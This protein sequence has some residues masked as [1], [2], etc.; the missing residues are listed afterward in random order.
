MRRRSR[1]ALILAA[2][3]LL[4]ALAGSG[5][6]DPGAARVLGVFVWRAPANAGFGGLSGIELGADGRTMT[7]L[8]DR[9]R[10]GRG[11][12]T[13]DAAGRITAA[14][15]GPLLRLHDEKG[16]L[17]PR[18]KAD[19]EGLAIAADGRI[20]ISFEGVHLLRVYRTPDGPGRPLPRA[21][22]FAGLPGNKSLETL[23]IDAQ[24]ALYT[25]PEAVSP[26]GIRIY[27]FAGGRWRQPWT[28]PGGDHGFHPVGADFGPDGRFYL[29][30]RRFAGLAGFQSRLR[31]FRLLPGGRFEAELM[32][33]SDL[34]QFDNLE[35]VA[36]WRAEDG[37]LR[38]TLVADDN[39]SPFQRTELVDLALP[40]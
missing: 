9:G 3:L 30:E 27:R 2:L 38:A 23:A 21:A 20:F 17:L 12:L 1:R 6:T 40:D 33:A 7:V 34:G 26:A 32:L 25:T 5:R 13:R 15:L 35:G 36:I 11:S 31:R 18:W 16:R 39:F 8:S 24:G 28:L 22:D 4:P 10:I 19:S 14:E 29:L 37:G